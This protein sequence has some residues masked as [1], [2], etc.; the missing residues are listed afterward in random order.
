MMRWASLL[1]KGAVAVWLS[2][3]V[4]FFHYQ[5]TRPVLSRP[6]VGRIYAWNNHGHIVYLTHSEQSNLY[7]LGGIGSCMMLLAIIFFSYSKRAASKD[8]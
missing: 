5:A 1:S 3:F 2:A 8:K 7:V 4:L 6:D